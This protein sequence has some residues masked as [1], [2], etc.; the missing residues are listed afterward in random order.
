VSWHVHYRNGDQQFRALAADRKTAISVA[1]ILFRDGHEV[2][3]IE[4]SAGEMI[5]THEIQRMCER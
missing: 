1:C 2:V 4:S 3:K 5:E